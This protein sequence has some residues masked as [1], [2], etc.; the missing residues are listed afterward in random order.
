MAAI[1]Y[2]NKDTNE[3]IGYYGVYNLVRVGEEGSIRDVQKRPSSMRG[4]WNQ[5]RN[6]G[7]E[8][9]E[10]EFVEEVA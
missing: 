3:I 9:F 7:L 6:A 10:A 5:A 4:A 1:V 2:R 8:N